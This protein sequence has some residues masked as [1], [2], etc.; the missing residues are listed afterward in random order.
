MLYTNN[1][2]YILIQKLENVFEKN[3]LC[4]ED[5]LS[6]ML[7]LLLNF[8]GKQCQVLSPENELHRLSEGD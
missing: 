6:R 8:F 1:I 7:Q 4:F 2:F 3:W 5:I